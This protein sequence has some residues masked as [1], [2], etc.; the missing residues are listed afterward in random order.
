M[1]DETLARWAKRDAA[2]GLDAELAEVRNALGARDN[3]I[4]DL[5]ERNERLAQRVA[6]LVTQRDGLARQLGA[7]QRPP[8]SQRL[9][10]KARSLV[11]RVVRSVRH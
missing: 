2:I 3:E 4:A 10:R 7:L 11:G 1:I 6:Q 9:Y 8:I 5:R